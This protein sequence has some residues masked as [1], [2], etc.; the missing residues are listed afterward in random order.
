VLGAGSLAGIAGWVFVYPIDVIKTKIQSEPS[1]IWKD[2]ITVAQMYERHCSRTP[3]Q[4][5]LSNHLSV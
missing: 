1:L 5:T 4:L 3:K 2:R